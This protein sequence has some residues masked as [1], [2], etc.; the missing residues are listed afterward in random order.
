MRRWRRGGDSLGGRRRSCSEFLAAAVV[1]ARS[2]NKWAA[3][4]SGNDASRQGDSFM[5]TNCKWQRR[6]V[7]GQWTSNTERSLR[8][9][10]STRDKDRDRGTVTN[11]FLINNSKK[12]PRR[13]RGYRRSRFYRVKSSNFRR[14]DVSRDRRA[15]CDSWRC[16]T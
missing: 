4:G 9:A 10:A 7:C 6:R 2:Q 16:V 1:G 13:L 5:N 11:I 15:R 3:T 12:R 8:K 14:D